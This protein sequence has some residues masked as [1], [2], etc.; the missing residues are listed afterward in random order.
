MPAVTPLEDE[1]FVDCVRRADLT[2]RHEPAVKVFTSAR[3]EGRA[4]IGLAR[5][6]H[7]WSELPNH[8]AHTVPSAEFLEYR[9]RFLGRLRRI[10]ADKDAGDLF[11]PTPWW[12][13]TVAQALVTER[14]CPAFLG[15]IYCD[16]LIAESYERDRCE[17]RHT[18]IA[19]A[20]AGLQAILMNTP[21]NRITARREP[22]LQATSA[23]LP[24]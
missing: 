13:D 14:T 23:S 21:P 2:L 7:C 6:F 20:I 12:R 11:L 1:A 22:P 15:A 16:T 18:P 9:F 3:L 4:K 8:D 19:Q 24:Q 17:D 10:Y 5:Q